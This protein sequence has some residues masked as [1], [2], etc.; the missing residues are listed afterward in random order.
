MA[1]IFLSAG[2]ASGELYAVQLMAALREKL[3]DAGFYGLGGERMAAAGFERVVRAEDVAVMGITEI[4]RH[5][6]KIYREY[7]K[8][9]RSL[10]NPKP[11]IA[12]LIDFPDVNLGLAK[13][14]KQLGIP[15]IFFVSPQVW[16]WKRYRLLRIR[17]DV[18]RMLVI[19][20]FEEPWYR[21]RGVQA[22]FVGHPLAELP[23]PSVTREAFAADNRLDTA[24]QWV[25]I[26]P[27]SRAG[28]IELN[29][30]EILAAV[31]QLARETPDRFEFVLPLAPTLTAERAERK[32]SKRTQRLS[33]DC[34]PT[35]ALPCTTLGQASSPAAPRPSRP[36]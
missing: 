24:K 12:V 13:R 22:S 15:V 6:P 4:L 19:F 25:A 21:E 27:G 1:R 10:D 33:F 17:R 8:L 26:L 2:E 5:V 3:P 18:D 11:D 35:P 36:R 14:C 34:L 32:L 30:P 31:T 16:A 23:L 20:P 9:R 7:R 29:L 28:E